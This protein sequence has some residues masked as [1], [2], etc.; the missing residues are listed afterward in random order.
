MQRID[1]IHVHVYTLF[2]QITPTHCTQCYFEY[3]FYREK[4][5]MEFRG[6]TKM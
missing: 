4:I 1:L 5:Y 3:H 6:G 2:V